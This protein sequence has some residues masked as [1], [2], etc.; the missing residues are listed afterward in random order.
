[1]TGP[2]SAWF[3]ARWRELVHAAEDA[4]ADNWIERHLVPL[5]DSVRDYEVRK[6]RCRNYVLLLAGSQPPRRQS[7]ERGQVVRSSG[8]ELWVES[9]DGTLGGRIDLVVE[10]ATGPVIRDYKTGAVFESVGRHAHGQG[11]IRNAAEALRPEHN[12]A[13]TGVWPSRLELAPL[14]GDPIAIEYSRE[15]CEEL[16]VDA[17]YEL[18]TLNSTD[19]GMEDPRECTPARPPN[20]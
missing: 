11:N 2:P 12:A 20:P 16:L 7:E 15:E 4:M 5:E 19:R 1:M 14:V 18:A 17:S 6:R 10:T 9:S 8:Y 13:V 3:E